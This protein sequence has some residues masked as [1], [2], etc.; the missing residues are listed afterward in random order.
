[1]PEVDYNATLLIAI[2]W[3]AL[4]R[5]K[6]GHDRTLE[7]DC[8]VII[9]FAYFF[10]EATLSQIMEKMERYPDMKAFVNNDHPG[11]LLKLGWFYNEYV[12]RDKA[13]TRE[14]MFD[15]GI[16]SKLYRKFPGFYKLREFRNDVAHGVIRRSYANLDL[17][18]SLRSKAKDIVDKLF[19]ISNSSGFDIPRGITY[20]ITTDSLIQ[21]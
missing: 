19:D 16:K 21:N 6:S 10:I 4:N 13:Q 5:A 17:A 8:T 11:L 9:L 18:E 7:C 1:M 3:Q 12:A 20:E 14:E 2:S 15:K